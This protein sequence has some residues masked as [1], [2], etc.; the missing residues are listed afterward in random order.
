MVHVVQ[1]TDAPGA[2]GLEVAPSQTP[3]QPPTCAYVFVCQQ[4]DLSG[5]AL[6][7]AASLRRFLRGSYELIAAIPQP[8]ATWGR[9]DDAVLAAL[10]AMD[11]KTMP[12]HNP[13]D[14]QLK[15]NPLTNKIYALQVPT[16]QD[17]LVF[18]DSDL[19]C[20]RPF[21]LADQGIGPDFANPF[22]AA[23]TFLATGRNWE[24]IY[25]AV[26]QPV[27]PQRIKTLFSEDRQ[28]PYF[29]SGFIS[30]DA[31]LAPKLTATWL[32]C[33]AKINQAGAMED[34]LYFREQ[35]C[36]ALAVITLGLEYHLLDWRY[37][38]WVK[39]Q[40]LDP[41][42]LPYFLHHT[43]PHPPL[44]HQPWLRNLVQSLVAEH[45]A[46][47]PYVA[48]CRWKYYLR[49][50]WEVAVNRTAHRHRRLLKRL[51]GKSLAQ[52]MIHGHG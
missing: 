42:N 49:P 9:P 19:L 3:E 27:P 6:L 47:A 23:P 7:L 18:L 37:N 38:Y 8:E 46:I 17:K 4:G 2:D 34:N 14:R 45:P 36:L 21:D 11:V 44:Y 26:G 20:L 28:P 50:T 48:R 29:N 13:I 24:Q 10:A 22:S 15:G 51:G 12:V 25:A 40:P 5:M 32:D 35:V 16:N 39:Y 1:S 30:L 41:Q 52:F 33:F 43:W 31:A